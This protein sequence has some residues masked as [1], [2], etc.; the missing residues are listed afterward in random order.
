MKPIVP[1]NVDS[2][3]KSILKQLLSIEAK[4]GT[5]KGR[6]MYDDA[7][8]IYDQGEVFS[9]KLLFIINQVFTEYQTGNL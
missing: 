4:A 2:Q 8:P 7:I 3:M 5:G 1:K 6:L 9:N